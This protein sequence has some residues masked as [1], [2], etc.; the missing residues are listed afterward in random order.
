M[1]DKQTET[2]NDTTTIHMVM[3][4]YGVW[5][6]KIYIHSF[7]ASNAVPFLSDDLNRKKFV[8]MLFDYIHDFGLNVDANVNFF[9]FSYELTDKKIVYYDDTRNF[10]LTFHQR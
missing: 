5:T 1:S 8:N 10:E 9:G 7:G 4:A 2:V 3:A 6:L